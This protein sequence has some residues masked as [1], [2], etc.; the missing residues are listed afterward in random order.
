MPP[1]PL[2]KEQLYLPRASGQGFAWKASPDRTPEQ[3]A[4]FDEAVDDLKHSRWARLR[5]A[6]SFLWVDY[7]TARLATGEYMVLRFAMIPPVAGVY[8][9]FVG[10][11]DEVAGW[12][13][14]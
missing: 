2:P 12:R 4:A 13:P 7:W 14:E 11:E 1:Q 3:L 10:T 6:A 5:L 8:I 9:L